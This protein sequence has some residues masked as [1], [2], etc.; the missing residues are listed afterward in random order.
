M[1][2]KNKKNIWMQIICL[3]Q[4]NLKI[5]INYVV[6]QTKKREPTKK[7]ENIFERS[8]S[9]KLLWRI[10]SKKKMCHIKEFLEDFG[11]LIIKSNLQIQFGESIW[12]KWLA[13]CFI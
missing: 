5:L 9:K 8:V 10:P 1:K 13:L 11:L 2:F 7:R 4:R 12:L 6:E 3:L